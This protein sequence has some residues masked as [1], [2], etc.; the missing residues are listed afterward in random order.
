MFIGLRNSLVIWFNLN[1]S[2]YH[3]RN[4]SNMYDV[5]R[6]NSHRLFLKKESSRSLKFSY[7]KTV[8]KVLQNCSAFFCLRKIWGNEKIYFQKIRALDRMGCR[9]PIST[10]SSMKGNFLGNIHVLRNHKRGWGVRKWQF[11]ITFSTESNHKPERVGVRKLQI[12]ITW[13]M[14]GPLGILTASHLKLCW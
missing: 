12:L 13:Y 6:Y 3:H 9:N 7:H 2:T 8:K 11:L 10:I 4:P 1:L 14:D 5:V